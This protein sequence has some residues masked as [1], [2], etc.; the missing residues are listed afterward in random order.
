MAR[1]LAE[2]RAI[3]DDHLLGVYLRGSLAL[4]DFDPHTSDVDLLCVV[5]Q[6]LSD[7][8]FDALRVMHQRLG[9]LDHLLAHDIEL[10]YLPRASAWEWHPWEQ[11][12]TLAR[13]EALGWNEHGANWLLERWAV[14]QGKQALFG[15]P[16]DTFFAPIQA[17]AVGA[18]VR[19]RLRDWVEFARRPEDPAW[20]EPLPH[21]AYVIETM[22]R[23]LATLERGALLSKPEA[24]R[25]GVAHLPEPWA[26]LARRVPAWKADQT[27]DADANAQ[28][29]AFIL[30]CATQADLEGASETE[31]C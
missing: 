15:P 22:C 14:L 12:P 29:Q 30:W 24:V 31:P 3:L 6:P 28:A 9:T 7:A 18:A 2:Q 21:T 13:G 10:A 23:I 16:P 8:V 19:A 5:D 17:A 27:V 25:W 1:L 4:G 26:G 20:R 11:H